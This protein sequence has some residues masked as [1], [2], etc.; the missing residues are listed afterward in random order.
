M[1]SVLSVREL[2]ATIRNFN[3]TI[4][5]DAEEFLN[6]LVN[7]LCDELENVGEIT[8]HIR[9]EITTVVGLDGKAVSSRKE[10]FFYLSLPTQSSNSLKQAFVKYFEDEILE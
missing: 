2:A 5:E 8:D 4:Q 9:G 7:R 3:A 6:G 1:L 10:D